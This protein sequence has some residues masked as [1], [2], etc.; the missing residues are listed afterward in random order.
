ML[1]VLGFLKVFRFSKN[2]YWKIDI[3]NIFLQ[4][5]YIIFNFTDI[6]IIWSFPSE[7]NFHNNY[8]KFLPKFFFLEFYSIEKKDS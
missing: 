7:I 2:I 1:R 6:Y 3:W 4:W 8:T 5:P